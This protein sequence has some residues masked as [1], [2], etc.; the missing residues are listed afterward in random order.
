MLNSSAWAAVA[1]AAAQALVRMAVFSLAVV[2]TN[3]PSMSRKGESF[4][5]SLNSA[6]DDDRLPALLGAKAENFLGDAG[7]GF[8]VVRAERAD[9]GKVRC[10]SRH[11]QFLAV[12]AIEFVGRVGEHCV[13]EDEKAALPSE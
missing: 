4:P 6:C 1:I 5:N 11:H 9:H 2:F 7:E 3:S 12:V 13:V 8:H 10:R